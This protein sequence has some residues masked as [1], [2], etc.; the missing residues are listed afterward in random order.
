MS[1]AL[2]IMILLIVLIIAALALFLT[3]TIVQL[4]KINRGLAVVIG[5]VG[6][7]VAKTAP[8]NGVLDAINSNLVLGRNLLEGLFVKKAGDD[9]GG[10]VESLFPGEGAKFLQRVGRRGPVVNTGVVYTRGV[11]ILASLGRGAPI[12]AAHARG[13]AVRDPKYATTAAAMLYPRPGGARARP[14]SPVVGKDAPQRYEATATPGVRPTT[15]EGGPAPAQPA[16]AQPAAPEPA[17]PTGRIRL[18]RREPPGSAPAPPPEPA[19]PAPAPAAPS[20]GGGGDEPPPASS[21]GRLNV[22][23]KR[24]WEG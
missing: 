4:V 21:P 9:A 11:G 14:K 16:P 22:R 5:A 1:L 20:S 3:A 10:L 7:I 19:A 12:G 2:A 17:A 23:A 15:R 13:P 18:R 6:E 8:V 24:P